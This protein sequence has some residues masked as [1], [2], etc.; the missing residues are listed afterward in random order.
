MNEWQNG[1]NKPL[2][3]VTNRYLSYFQLSIDTWASTTY[4]NKHQ[5]N[6]PPYLSSSGMQ[7]REVHQNQTKP[8]DVTDLGQG[9][10]ALLFDIPDQLVLGEL[11]ALVDVEFRHMDS[12][13]EVAIVR[14]SRSLPLHD[15]R[16]L[17]LG[18]HNRAWENTKR[19]TKPKMLGLQ[20]ERNL[21]KLTNIHYIL[22]IFIVW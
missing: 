21:I 22:L 7:K 15:D 11:K 5:A 12:H 17:H 4:K 16:S 8:R 10:K 13:E 3:F 14:S 1:L 20:E 18:K 9:S 2:R 6:T 19:Q